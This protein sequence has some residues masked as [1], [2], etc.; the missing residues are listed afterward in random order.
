M[1]QFYQ[2]TSYRIS[3]I[4]M[5]LALCCGLLLPVGSLLAQ[6][7]SPF[8]PAEIVNDE[9]G[10]VVVSGEVSYTNAFFT[11]GVAAPMVILEDQAGFV[12][13]NENFILPPESQTLGQITTDFYTSP[14]SYTVALPIE[15]QA[16]LRDVDNDGEEDT[17]VMVYAIAYWTNIFGDPFLEERDL[18]GGG[19]STAYASTRV[20]ED[21]STKREIIGGDFLVY[22]PD[23]QQGF[24]SG[25]GEDGLLFTEDDPIVGLPAGY[26][27]VNMDT[28][29]FTFDRSAEPEIDLI[30]PEGV[31][32]SDFSGMSYSEAFDAMIEKMRKEYAFTEYKDIDWDAKIEEFR[33]RFAEAEEN[34]D[35]R[36]YRKALSDFAWSIP[37]GHISGP[38]IV[39]DFQ[40]ET[41]GGLGIA[42]RELDDG[43]TV[44]N[45]V[46]DGSPAAEAGMELGTEII[47]I[48]GQPIA[49]AIS[50][51]VAWSAPFS[52]DHFRRLQQMRYVTRFVDGEEV[53]VTFQNPGGEEQTVTMTAIPERES[54]SFSSFNVGLTGFEL[55][56]EYRLL[57]E[58]YGYVKIYG[59]ADNDLLSIQLWERMI[60][61]LN[62]SQVPGLIID[63][64]QN[65][66]G[67]GFLADQMAAYFFDEPLELGNSGRY[68]EEIGD[69]YFDERGIDRYYLP[70]E[71]LRYHGEVAVLIGPNCNSA[72]EFFSYDMTVEERA[73]IVGQYPTAGLGGSIEDF[74]MPENERFR[75]T[76]GRAVDMNGEIH[77]EGKGVPP[78]VD[79][80]VTE[81]TIFT[82]GDPI[83]DA[84]IEHL[85]AETNVEMVDGGSIAIG[86]EVTGE[87]AAKS[88]V[89]YTIDVSAGDVIDIYLG[90]EAGELDTFLTLLDA[91]EN[92][93]LANDDAEVAEGEDATVN[94]ALTELEIPV[95]LTLIIEVSTAN[96]EGEGTYTLSV[97][98]TETEE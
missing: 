31:A 19:W 67:S 49:D 44:V 91:G 75:F 79:V 65:G 83:L 1:D 53:E 7:E 43:R 52:T 69:F 42:V 71:D 96:D 94:S 37:D 23:D 17:G 72:C 3:R 32:M 10:A 84:A 57:D 39:E 73:A 28:D 68:N 61:A 15:P 38:F 90:D 40:F 41:S 95:D 16:S 81:E 64:R 34:E 77:I 46:L 92:T 60:R 2:H 78:T 87:I 98:R 97:Q 22:A 6:D 12:D 82:D 48:D 8:P 58:G 30:E 85:D 63:M 35:A 66:G 88:R 51:A 50:D 89:R 74:M 21:V 80:P 93:L 62:Q 45:F 24:P 14:F 13:R 25:F 20:S 59:F 70:A 55:P 9:G 4:L 18:Y 47:A 27:V 33:P 11:V 5:S 56:V 86:E 26:T 76:V 29:P 36:A 54:F